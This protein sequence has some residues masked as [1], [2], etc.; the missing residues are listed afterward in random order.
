MEKSIQLHYAIPQCAESPVC[1][2]PLGRA[3]PP[4]GIF[5]S[6]GEIR[7]HAYAT[8]VEY[9]MYMGSVEPMGQHDSELGGNIN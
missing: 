9:S 7:H 2:A 8:A 1:I 5:A 4:K 3:P 6:A